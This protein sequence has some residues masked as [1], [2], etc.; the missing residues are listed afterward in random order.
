[1]N[2]FDAYRFAR[3]I[4]FGENSLGNAWILYFFPQSYIEKRQQSRI[5]ATTEKRGELN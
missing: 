4:Q 3:V 5:F 2:M 1:M